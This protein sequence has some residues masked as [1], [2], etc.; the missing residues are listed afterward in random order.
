MIARHMTDTAR[1][2]LTIQVKSRM[3]LARKYQNKDIWIAFIQDD[4]IFVFP[5][6]LVLREFHDLQKKKG[7]PVEASRAWRDEGI[8]HW[9]RLTKDL[10]KILAPYR[11][12][13]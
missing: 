5:H 4:D 11:L 7:V 8:I 12:P 6:D 13:S 9:R 10:K 2:T 3:T 1:K